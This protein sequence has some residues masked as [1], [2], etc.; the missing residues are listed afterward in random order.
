M[1]VVCLCCRKHLK[2]DSLNGSPPQ[3]ADDLFRLLKEAATKFN[4]PQ[5]AERAQEKKSRRPGEQTRQHQIPH[6]YKVVP[7]QCV[8]V[9][10]WG[11]V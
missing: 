10:V 3:D 5:D 4:G 9:C 1:K 8:T 7:H 11:V 6:W 2:R